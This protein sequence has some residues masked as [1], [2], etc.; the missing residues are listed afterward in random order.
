M[1]DTT[2]GRE[3]SFLTL[4][5]AKLRRC[6]AQHPTLCFMVW[7]AGSFQVTAAIIAAAAR[8]LHLHW[9]PLLFSLF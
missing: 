9:Q 6:H 1:G 3:R 4:V 5:Q 2:V 7:A 8:M